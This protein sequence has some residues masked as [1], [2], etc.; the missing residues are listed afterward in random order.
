ME[1]IFFHFSKLF[2]GNFFS[3][4]IYAFIKNKE[5]V[6]AWVKNEKNKEIETLNK[7]EKVI[8]T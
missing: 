3:E 7:N 5:E 8:F 4:D 2:F 1:K 6:N